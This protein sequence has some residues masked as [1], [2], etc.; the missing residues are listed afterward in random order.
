MVGPFL[1]SDLIKDLS[2]IV[3]SPNLIRLNVSLFAVDFLS[4]SSP[5]ALTTEQKPPLITEA[6]EENICLRAPWRS[7][8]S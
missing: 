8:H 5:V 2:R 6:N 1:F 7:S 4:H 3:T